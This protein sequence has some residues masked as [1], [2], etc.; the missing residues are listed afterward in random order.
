MR[1]AYVISTLD[2]CGPV[3]VLYDIVEPLAA[4]NEIAVFTLAAEPATSRIADFEALGIAVSCV[5]KTRIDSLLNGRRK[6]SRALRSFGAEVVHAHGYRAYLLCA[7]L[8]LPTVATVHNCLYDDFLPEYGAR[9]AKWMTRSELRALMRFDLVLACS[10]SNAACLKERYGL[11]AGSIR[12]GVSQR[13]YH[14]VTSDEKQE[15]RASLGIP[16]NVKGIFISTGGCTQRK[17]TLDLIAWFNRAFGDDPSSMLLIFG[18]GPLLDRCRELAGANVRLMGFC[19]NVVPWLQVSDCFVSFSASEGMPLAV[20]E[21]ISCGCFALLSDIAP[22]R[23]IVECCQGTRAHLLPQDEKDLWALDCLCLLD[24]AAQCEPDT[25][26]FG[27]RAMAQ[28]Y[29]D[30]YGELLE[31]QAPREGRAS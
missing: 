18:E 3:N 29:F 26:M 19:S 14:P 28:A 12:N 11:A 7:D 1:I 20:L 10:A 9:Q 22:H 16:E 5:T 4:D 25:S 13:V 17:R 2:R 30:S 27:S 6:L 31:A 15:L 23:E 21:A 8:D 24:A